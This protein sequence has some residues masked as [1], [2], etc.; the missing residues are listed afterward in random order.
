MSAPC[1]AYVTTD[2][3]VVVND[4]SVEPETVSG[5][6]NWIT[7]DG[8]C[9]GGFGQRRSAAG[10]AF[11][12]SSIVWVN[13]VHLAQISLHGSS[14][15]DMH[16]AAVVDVGVAALSYKHVLFLPLTDNSK[17]AVCLGSCSIAA[18]NGSAVTQTST[19]L[20][21]RTKVARS[22]NSFD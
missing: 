7:L 9:Y 19:A 14:Q 6:N 21:A 11:H 15:L 16:A 20:R 5:D 8:L 18:T 3:Q 4:G 12:A 10:T 13:A 1:V 17:I 22:S 2:G